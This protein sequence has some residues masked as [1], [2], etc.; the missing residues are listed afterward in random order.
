[1]K[2][3]KVHG[4]GFGEVLQRVHGSQK[5]NKTPLL[6]QRMKHMNR[7]GQKTNSLKAV[8]LI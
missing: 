5:W 6:K 2:F 4:E 1:L 3:D 7:M 8:S